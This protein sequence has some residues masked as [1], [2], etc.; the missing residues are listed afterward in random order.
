MEVDLLLSSHISHYYTF[1]SLLPLGVLGLNAVNHPRTFRLAM[2]F[3]PTLVLSKLL[4][5]Q[6]MGKFSPPILVVPCWMEAS[7]LSTVLNM[8]MDIPCCCPII[9]NLVIDVSLAWMLKGLP[10][11]QVTPGLLRYVCYA[12]WGSLPQFFRQWQG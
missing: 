5:E 4:A 3:L 1:E 9:K 2:C 7:Q 12:D 6:V 11:L 8:L 10:Y